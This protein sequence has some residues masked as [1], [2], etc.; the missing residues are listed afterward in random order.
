MEFRIV[1]EEGRSIGRRRGAMTS[2]VRVVFEQR[3]YLL[4]RP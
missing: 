4:A 1:A 2:S 3:V